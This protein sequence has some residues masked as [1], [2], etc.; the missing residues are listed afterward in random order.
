[1]KTTIKFPKSDSFAFFV[2]INKIAKALDNAFFTVKENPDEEPVL[3]KK[4]GAGIS[5]AD[6]RLY[7][8]QLSYKV[9]IDGVDTQFMEVGVRYFFDVKGTIGNAQK[10]FLWGELIL[11]ETETGYLNPAIQGDT[12]AVA[13]VYTATFETGAPSQYVETESDPVA[14]A[15]IGDMTK[16]NTTAKDTLVKAINEVNAPTFTESATLQNVVSGEKQSTLWGKVKKWLTSLK[17]LAFKDKV[18]TEDITDGAVTTAKFSS[19]ARCPSATNADNAKIA[20]KVNNIEFVYDSGVIK[21]KISRK[22]V[23]MI[24]GELSSNSGTSMYKLTTVETLVVGQ[25]LVYNNETAE[26][27]EYDSASDYYTLACVTGGQFAQKTG[28]IITVD[29]DFSATIPKRELL[30]SGNKSVGTTTSAM[31]QISGRFNGSVLEIY[32]YAQYSNTNT[33]TKYYAK[34]TTPSSVS[35]LTII[36]FAFYASNNVTD[37][38]KVAIYLNAD[39]S[40]SFMAQDAG[41]GIEKIYKISE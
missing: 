15:K 33:N 22:V 8:N 6:S 31:A 40:L 24:G 18:V 41:V 17:A 35:A 39:G 38:K 34:F 36:S 14:T 19:D 16:L 30:W 3:Q 32:Y 13:Q 26:I 29:V 5:L 20:K 10:T 28:E 21:G 12:T 25:K 7:K 37:V 4:L 27:T 2:T 23:V 9:Q 1:M 11:S